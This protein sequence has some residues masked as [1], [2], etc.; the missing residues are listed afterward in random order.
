MPLMV[1]NCDAF[2][3][4]LIPCLGETGKD[5]PLSGQEF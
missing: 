2:T 3:C 5:L 1:D 4:K